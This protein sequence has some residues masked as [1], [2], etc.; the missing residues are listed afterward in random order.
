MKVLV[1]C[2]DKVRVGDL[3]GDR[4]RC[5]RVSLWAKGLGL[6]NLRSYLDGSNPSYPHPAWNVLSIR[7]ITEVTEADSLNQI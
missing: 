1:M 3:E 7:E 5:E 6:D 4:F 2:G